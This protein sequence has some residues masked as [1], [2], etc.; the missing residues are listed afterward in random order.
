MIFS[1]YYNNLYSYISQDFKSKIAL[2]KIFLLTL[3]PI[4]RLKLF[5]IELAFLDFNFIDLTIILTLVFSSFSKPNLFLVI[6]Y[7]KTN[8]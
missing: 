4:L 5:F 1:Y 6:T 3:K 8:W 7:S 2:I